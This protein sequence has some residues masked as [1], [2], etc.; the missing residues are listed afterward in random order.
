VHWLIEDMVME[1]LPPGEKERVSYCYWCE[2]PG[3]KG[4]S[5]LVFKGPSGLYALFDFLSRFEEFMKK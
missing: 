5:T 1:F 4:W 2:R 3:I